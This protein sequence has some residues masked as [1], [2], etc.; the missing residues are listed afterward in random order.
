MNETPPTPATHPHLGWRVVADA[1]YIVFAIVPR[2]N[3]LFIHVISTRTG[4]R[5]DRPCSDPRRA[6]ARV[7]D[8]ARQYG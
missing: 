7:L 4:N 5:L 1:P 8:F 2:P 3:G 6:L